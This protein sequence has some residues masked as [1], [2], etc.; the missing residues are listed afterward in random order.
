MALALLFG[1][2]LA[3]ALADI[4]GTHSGP[5]NI[6][7]FFFGEHS[8]LVPI[9][10]QSVV[11]IRDL[12]GEFAMDR[13]IAQHI[14]HVVGCHERVVHSHDFHIVV[15]QGGAEDQTADPAKS[16]DTNFGFHRKNSFRTLYK[17]NL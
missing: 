1:Q 6:A 10:H 2:V 13:V 3:S 7:H 11:L 9:H 5:G 16:I 12:A 15:G 8:D 17:K 14:G 4:L